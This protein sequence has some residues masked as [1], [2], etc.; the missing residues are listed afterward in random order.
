MYL[1]FYMYIKNFHFIC[2]LV[3]FLV[4]LYDASQISFVYRTGCMGH[5]YQSHDLCF[6]VSFIVSLSH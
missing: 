3:L 5:V 1:G 6:W 2:I 4:W